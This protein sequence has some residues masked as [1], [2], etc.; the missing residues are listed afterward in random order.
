MCNIGGILQLEGVCAPAAL[1]ISLWL[2][3]VICQY[4][5]QTGDSGI[6]DEMAHFL[7]GRLLNSDEDSYYDLPI[8]SDQA[9]SL[10]DHCVLA[11]KNGLRFGEH[12]LPLIGS[13]DWNDGMDRVGHHGKGESVW[14]GFFLYDILMQFSEIARSKNDLVFADHCVD[15]AKRLNENI[16]KNAWDG[17]WYRRAWFDDGTTLGFI[18]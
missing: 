4:I 18:N 11:I 3:F 5:S 16:E 15:Q 9:A 14:L 12:G 6:M 13:G 17:E 7:E 10:Y 2:P 1:M 8:K